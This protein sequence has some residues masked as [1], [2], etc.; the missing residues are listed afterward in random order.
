MTSN[1][2]LR[3]IKNFIAEAWTEYPKWCWT[4]N[5]IPQ[6]LAECFYYW[7]RLNEQDKQT[8][9]QLIASHGRFSERF[10][11]YLREKDEKTQLL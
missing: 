1:D 4:K 3:H 2:A 5:R 7:T 8:A 9:W 10:S 11:D 6:A